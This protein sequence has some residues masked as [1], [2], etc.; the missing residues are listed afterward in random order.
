[1]FQCYRRNVL[2]CVCVPEILSGG[3]LQLQSCLTVQYC[4]TQRDTEPLESSFNI[5]PSFFLF[6]FYNV[7]Y[8]FTHDL[9]PFWTRHH[10]IVP[11]RTLKRILQYAR[12]SPKSSHVSDRPWSKSSFRHML[13]LF[14]RVY[15]DPV[16]PLRLY[17]FSFTVYC[18]ANVG[19]CSSTRGALAK[20][21]FSQCSLL[22]PDILLGLYYKHTVWDHS[23]WMR[24]GVKEGSPQLA[25]RPLWEHLL[26]EIKRT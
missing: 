15:A 12:N 24:L 20:A 25:E 10:V 16:F 26:S 1:M 5:M 2:F 17:D 14:G 19:S 22:V 21:D 4:Y 8:P 6:F 11:D 13:V 18:R 3:H 7:T 9:M 23:L